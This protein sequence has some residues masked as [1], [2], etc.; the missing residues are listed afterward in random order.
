MQKWVKFW[1]LGK[2]ALSWEGGSQSPIALRS[3]VKTQA[4]DSNGVPH[5]TR[6][7]DD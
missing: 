5:T 4:I 2:G 7:G 1:K 6:C 3:S